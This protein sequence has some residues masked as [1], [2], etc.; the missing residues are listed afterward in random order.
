M[1]FN[2]KMNLIDK[3]F[4]KKEKDLINH[5]TRMN[6]LLHGVS[7]LLYSY[8]LLQLLLI[9]NKKNKFI[10]I[11]K[12]VLITVMANLLRHVGHTIFDTSYKKYKMIHW[13][14]LLITEFISRLIRQK[15]NYRPFINIL[16]EP[17]IDTVYYLPKL[18]VN[19]FKD[20]KFN[21]KI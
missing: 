16:L 9:F 20:V 14:I 10:A 6:R 2:F 17:F 18:F 11:D 3:L 15:N 7:G 13:Y 12:L 8:S 4:N 1:F 19:Y 21:N 5:K